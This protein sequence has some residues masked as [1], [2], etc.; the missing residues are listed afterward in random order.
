MVNT[1]IVDFQ[2]HTNHGYHCVVK[3]VIVVLPK[4]ERPFFGLSAK[5]TNFCGTFDCIYVDTRIN[6]IMME[7]INFADRPSLVS[8][9]MRELRDVNIG[10]TRCASVP[11]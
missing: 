3:V 11:T 5:M 6:H 4:V 9:Y 8:R 2:N 10:T 7:I 1:V